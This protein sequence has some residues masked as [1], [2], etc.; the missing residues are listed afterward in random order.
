MF[1]R[2]RW[3][4]QRKKHEAE[5]QR[6]LEAHLEIETEEQ[7][8]FGLTPAEARAA[9]HRAFGNQT[10]VMEQART[11]WRWSTIESIAQDASF[12][13]RML[14]KNRAFA[15]IA[16][17]TLAFG[18]A[19]NTVIFSVAQAALR[20]LRIP[21]AENVVI[22]HTEIPD[23]D[24]HHLPASVPDF[25]DLK[26]SGVFSSLAAFTDEGVNM[27]L[28]DRSERVRA[29]FVTA[30]FFEVVGVQ[31]RVGRRF[32]EQETSP[33]G[34]A[35]AILSEKAWASRF[36]ADRDILGRTVLFDGTP[37]TVIGVLPADFPQ[38]AQEEIYLPLVFPS[39]LGVAR[40]RRSYPVLGRL[41]AGLTLPAGQQRVTEIAKQ[42]AESYEEDRGITFRLQ[43]VEE[44]L[45]EN[46]QTLL[47]VLFGA[48]GFVL[49][50]A[51]TNVA[52]LL[53][54]RGTVRHR[55]MTIRSALGAG[56]WKLSRQL[57]TE[58]LVLAL[59]GGTVAI[60]PAAIGIDF[61]T[62]LQ[63]DEVPHIEFVSMNWR[64]LLFTFGVALLAGILFGC[65]P[66]FQ[67]WRTKM[68]A[69]LATGGRS[70]TGGMHQRL[71]RALVIGEITLTVVV[72]VASGLMIR[73][74]L[75]LRSADPGY[76]SHDLLTM[77]V[78]LAE[79]Q[80]DDAAKQELFFNRLVER[81]REIPGLASISGSSELPGTDNVHVSGFLPA[82]RPKPRREDVPVVLYDSV[83]TGYFN[84]MQMPLLKGRYFD[85]SDRGNSRLVAIID[86]W[87]ATKN[88]PNEKPIGRQFKLGSAEQ[89]FEVVGVVKNAEQ[90]SI[91]KLA[92]GKV[93]Q[94]YIPF[95]QAPKA[96][97]SLVVRTESDPALVI[98]AV[99][100]VLRGI[101][102]DQPLYQIRLMDDARA[103]SRALQRL[104]T[105]LLGAFGAI[106][107]LLASVGVY[108][109]VAFHV[110]ERTREFGIRMSVGAQRRDV[111][112]MVLRQG[113]VLM[114]VGLGIGV[115]GAFGVSRVMASLLFQIGPHDLLTFATV[116][117]LLAAVIFLAC[118]VPAR[119]ATR[120]DPLVALRLE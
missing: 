46:A 8:E 65:M 52:G 60:V 104:G 63:L 13:L 12:A 87:T 25:M 82:G 67:V 118:Y 112:K 119:R 54:A 102:I 93:G 85:E 114:T 64:V 101:D 55:E 6:E 106:A 116:T 31:P 108:G 3:F 9:A 81:A 80:Y 53:M 70:V 42:L 107:L 36:A 51:C 86:E 76:N 19:G 16:I 117:I 18:I 58:S 14:S 27:R 44:S 78:A 40:G 96:A 105:T 11:A 41:Q 57:M 71:R 35:V 24:M 26:K 115:V 120:I 110:G 20:P 5:M 109:V 100:E 83:L 29:L 94:V 33:G 4:L 113:I 72:L 47:T 103:T 48:V 90:H 50:I 68:T 49:L 61:V 21:N 62:S 2:L 30:A 75:R 1:A 17:L 92:L 99:R 73:S 84:T 10:R 45:I 22:V 32:T 91:I 15:V 56:R 74:F 28:G 23:R 88:W 37:H 39:T 79:R 98:S 66:A 89:L 111:L 95:A 7:L 38:L 34:A 59:L 97:V 43:A 77:R 69:S